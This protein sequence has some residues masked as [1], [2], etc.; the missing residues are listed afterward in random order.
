MSSS[1]EQFLV[2]WFAGL[3]GWNVWNTHGLSMARPTVYFGHGFF[4]PALPPA[5]LLIQT[6]FF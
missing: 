1:H 6:F 3:P 2:K 4:W 5:F